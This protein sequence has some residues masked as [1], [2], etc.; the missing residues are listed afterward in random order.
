MTN[1]KFVPRIINP[2]KIARA[3]IFSAEESVRKAVGTLEENMPWIECSVFSD[4]LSVSNYQSDLATVF[5]LDDT[6]MA[7][8]D[9]EKIHKNNPDA[10]IVL[11]SSNDL[12]HRS[13]PSVAEDQYPYT[14]RAD[15]IFAANTTEFLPDLIVTSVVR[16]AEDL[17]NIEQY[18]KVRRY[19]FLIVDDEP[20]WF[21]QFLPVLYKIIGQRAD[22]K[23]TRTHEETL[24]FIFGVEQESEI[25]R[26]NYLTQGHGDD[27]VCLITD[28]FFPKGENQK[29]KAGVDLIRLMNQYYPR[30]PTIIASKAKEAEDLKGLTYILP[31]GD[32]GSIQTLREYIHD[33][34]GIGDFLVID[35]D[36]KVLDRARHIRELYK[37]VK[38]AEADTSEARHL[39]DL[40]EDF[41]RND[42]FSTWLYMHGFRDLADRLR[43]IQITGK[44][45]IAVLESHLKEEIQ[46]IEKIPLIIDGVEIFGLT[47]LLEELRRADPVKI[48]KLSDTDTFSNWFDIKCYPELAE[49]FR[50]IHGSGEKLSQTL[51]D[52]VEKWIKIY[53]LP[54]K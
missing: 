9:S 13:P 27:I 46:R 11:L 26:I 18:S 24:Q 1:P 44:E 33:H 5:L 22:V 20:R 17:L 39:R 23:V 4:P 54:Q 38:K 41:G 28:V 49:E 31:K 8:V 14:A 40:L 6:S 51:A 53:G 52:I 15:L 21:S 42:S 16:C 45:M 48:Q 2:V 25:D 29:S 43:P 30:I 10:V 37:I 3:V 32:P 12:I 19:I 7:F 36:G 35:K 47:D 50:P 34:T